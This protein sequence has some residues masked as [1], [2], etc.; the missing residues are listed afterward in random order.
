MVDLRRWAP[1]PEI[2]TRHA[3][4]VAAPADRTWRAAYELPVDEVGLLGRLVRWRIPH[5]PRPLSFGALLTSPPFAVLERHPHALVAG[6]CGRIWTLRRDYAR[7]EDA[8]DYERWD[9]EGTAKVAIGIWAAPHPGGSEL[10]AEA[11]V[12]PVDGRAALRLKALWALVGRFE[13]LI[14]SQALAAAQRRA[15]DR[16]GPRG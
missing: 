9:A 13:G 3:R 14:D 1:E 15:E 11:R 16:A 10:V 6:L 4:A 2:H 7:L 8:A 12:Q 5:L